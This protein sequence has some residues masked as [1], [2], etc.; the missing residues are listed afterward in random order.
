MI[1]NILLKDG[2]P[3]KLSY[4]EL[5]HFSRC[6]EALSVGAIEVLSHAVSILNKQNGKTLESYSY[7]IGFSQLREK[8]PDISPSLLMGLVGELNA[9]N[10]FHLPG[11]PTI[12]THS[13]GNY[14]IE[15]TPLGERFIEKVID[16]KAGKT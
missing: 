3:E 13:Y 6:L 14:Y 2:D 11:A 16:E 15:L 5:D 1:A 10:L 12:R 4:T 7:R 9:M 8:M